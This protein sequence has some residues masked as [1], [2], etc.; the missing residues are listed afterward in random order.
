MP[1]ILPPAAER[2]W[3]DME[4]RDTQGL[5]AMLT[6][7][8]AAAMRC[9]RVS[10]KVNAAGYEGPEGIVPVTEREMEYNGRLL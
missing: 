10:E 3:L 6:P 5:A 8:P 4:L 1:V 7:Y 2:A 9:Y